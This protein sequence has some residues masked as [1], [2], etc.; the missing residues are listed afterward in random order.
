[1]SSALRFCGGLRCEVYTLDR[2]RRF[3][4]LSFL[5]DLV[6]APPF[7]NSGDTAWQLTAATF[8][9]MQSIPGLAI[10][11]AGLVKK[12][13]A[14]NSAVM[15]FYA[16]S[17]VLLCWVLWGY[18]MGFGNPATLGPGILSQIVGIPGPA[19][20][21]AGELGQANIPLAGSALP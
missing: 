21:A 13:W 19:I 5:A 9:G 7:V 17:I 12:K 10:L 4:V 1:M 6:P 14:L 11:Y 3:F 18:N 2:T 16:F 15:C 8:V 20:S